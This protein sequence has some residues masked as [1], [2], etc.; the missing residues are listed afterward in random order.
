MLADKDYAAALRYYKTKGLVA[1]AGAVFG[2]KFQEQVMRWL[3]SKD[4]AA[5]VAT[6]RAAIPASLVQVQ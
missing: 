3:R 6:L 2:V 4:A 5:L 1:E